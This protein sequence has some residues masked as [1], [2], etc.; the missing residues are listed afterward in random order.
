MC[1][2]SD[3]VVLAVFTDASVTP[4]KIRSA[5]LFILCPSHCLRKLRLLIGEHCSEVYCSEVDTSLVVR[6]ECDPY[7]HGI[8]A[9][10]LL[11]INEQ[12]L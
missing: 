2:N 5:G 8:W 1:L 4:L 6:S 11:D 12:I 9:C 3:P 7:L 10:E